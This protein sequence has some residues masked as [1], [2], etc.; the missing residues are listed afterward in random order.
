[1]RLDSQN[2]TPRA[3]RKVVHAG[4]H[5]KS[6]GMGSKSLN[7]L[8]EWNLNATRVAELTVQS[9]REMKEQ[10][11][12]RVEAHHQCEARRPLSEPRPAAA[13]APDNLPQV[14]VV[15]MDGGRIRTRQE[16]ERRGVTEPHWREFQAGCVVRLQ[17]EPSPEDPHP[18]VPRLFLSRPKV[19]KLVTQLHRQKTAAAEEMIRDVVDGDVV[20]GESEASIGEMLR[21]AELAEDAGERAAKDT[22]ATTSAV[23]DDPAGRAAAVNEEAARFKRPVR[24]Q[25]TC[26]ATLEG[27]DACGR[28]LAAESAARG[29]DQA[30]RK[31]FLGDGQSSIWRV[32]QCYFQPLGYLGILDFVH[33][34]SYVYAIAMAVG[35]DADEGWQRYVG[36]ITALWQ[37]R[38]ADVLAQWRALAA[39]FEVPAEEAL[40]ENDPRRPIQRAVTYLSH[41]LE[42][43]DYPRYRQLGLPVTST[44]M[45]SLVKEF[46]H[47]VKGT[48]KFWNDPGGAEAI[49]TVRAALLSEDDRFAEHFATRPGC[50][51]RRR[52]TLDAVQATQAAAA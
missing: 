25:R 38:G 35:R 26:V 15:E 40:P 20:E 41:N 3:R 10:Q 27:A 24:L 22:P 17:S 19:Q 42:R 33:L 47:R 50:R 6:F 39:D 9:G 37:G 48:E 34:L 31:G 18:E 52:S 46:N 21:E 45:E 13:E 43:V 28:I 5:E 36:W 49:L 51:Y 14:G 44:L 30:D 16:N 29:L 7:E 32:W 4:G 2:L 8:A 1:L 11:T 23:G 12:A